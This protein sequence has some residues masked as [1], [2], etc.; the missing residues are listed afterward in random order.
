MQAI[1]VEKPERD[2]MSINRSILAVVI[3]SFFCFAACKEENSE[4]FI[5]ELPLTPPFE[6]FL[7]LSLIS[8]QTLQTENHLYLDDVG[9]KGVVVIKRGESDYAA[10][11][12]NCPHEPERDCAIVSHV[13]L[14]PTGSYLECGC[15]ESFYNDK[16]FPTS[17][18]S[19]RKLREYRT[20][21]S[22]NN[23]IV[24]DN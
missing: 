10:F 11:E 7:N 9:L 5:D 23:L 14:G 8:N 21:L 4:A 13:N 15:G 3:L 16:G 24:S 12:R 2:F 18:P 17:G 19:P 1:M 20:Q 22:G 6:V